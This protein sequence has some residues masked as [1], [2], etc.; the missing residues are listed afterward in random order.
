[1]FSVNPLFPDNEIEHAFPNFA[2][3][4]SDSGVWIRGEK[5]STWNAQ[6]AAR[7]WKTGS[8]GK[9]IDK[10]ITFMFLWALRKQG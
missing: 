6:I 4:F 2:L 10:Q 9:Q 8:K 7:L 5:C 3:S 1:M